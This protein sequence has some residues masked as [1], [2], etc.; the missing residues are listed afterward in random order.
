MKK[1]PKQNF[2]GLLFTLERSSIRCGSFINF[3]DAAVFIDCSSSWQHH[4]QRHTCYNF[5]ENLTPN[6]ILLT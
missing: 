4:Y 6:K 5:G 1:L 3:I 2:H